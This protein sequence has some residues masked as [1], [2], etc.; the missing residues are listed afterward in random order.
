M[1]DST[2][3][4]SSA[5]R[6]AWSRRFLSVEP[7]E[8]PAVLAGVL[9]FFLLFTGYFMLRPVRETM[10]VAGGIKNLQWLFTGT[11][12]ATLAT[13][14]LFGWVAG[15]FPRRTI[16]PWLFGLFAVN[17]LF[18]AGAL[19]AAPDNVWIA[20]GFYIWLSVFNLLT[21]SAGWSVLVD[22]F[23]LREAKRLFAL[24]AGGGSLGG[25][26]GP[27]LGALLVGHIG[28]AGLLVLSAL[29]LVAS[30]A[31]AVWLHRWRQRNPLPADL[32]PEPEPERLGGNPFAG[33]ID[34]FRSP[35]LL[36]I[37]VFVLLLTSVTTFLYFEQARLVA[38]AFP[39]K[40]DQTRVFGLIDATVQALSIVGQFFIT[41]HVARRL[42]LGVLLVG[43]PLVMVGGFVALAIA[44]TFAVF[45]V[46]MVVRRAGE[47]AFIRP[48]REMLY[49]VI[50][51]EQ[52]YKAKSFIDT[53][54]YRGGDAVSGWVK[55]GFDAV[56][57]NPTAAM[58]VG[59]VLA[60]IWA[61]SGAWLARAQERHAR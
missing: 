27:L 56:T 36:G 34:T 21:I 40:A 10:G 58:L 6:A 45:V 26:L 48:G 37:G 52:K 43:V 54:V 30:G 17:L 53:V 25:L 51:T 15:R 9:M 8:A 33:A 23:V 46:I 16:V 60:L 31:A 4:S 49:T 13:V 18:F 35:Y 28:H 1:S 19:A 50:G 24:A 55:A 38:E 22:V 29:L 11:F 42:G 5:A 44:P 41:G 39:K 57:S 12:V 20:R 14:P 61:G 2:S 59:G 47:Y 3:P 32:A 7:H